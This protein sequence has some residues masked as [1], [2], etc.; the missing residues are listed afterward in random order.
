MKRPE[1]GFALLVQRLL[2]EGND[3]SD[4]LGYRFLEELNGSFC[5]VAD[6]D[7]ESDHQEDDQ[8]ESQLAGH[9]P[10]ARARAS[11]EGRAL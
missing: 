6:I 8:E 4:S 2:D 10:R 7:P 11:G 5:T 9:A 3:Q 1:K